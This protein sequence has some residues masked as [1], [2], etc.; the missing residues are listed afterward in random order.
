MR[1]K[2]R[3]EYVLEW[4]RSQHRGVTPK[5]VYGALIHSVY[6]NLIRETAEADLKVLVKANYLE[7]YEKQGRWFYDTP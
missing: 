6:V 7:R 1:A 2:E 3:R 4:V 5:E